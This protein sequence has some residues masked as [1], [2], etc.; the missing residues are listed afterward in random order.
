MSIIIKSVSY[1]HSDREILFQNISFAINKGEKAALVGN[2]GTGKSTL[3]QIIAGQLQASAGEVIFTEKPYYVPQ[4]LG[5]YDN[6]T[7]AQALGIEQ[8]LNAYKA[9]LNGDASFENFALLNDDWMIEERVQSAFDY[10]HL[11]HLPLHQSMHLLSGGEKTKVFLAG[12]LIHGPGIVL[13]DEP[14]NHL[15]L[16]S[17]ELLY[18]FNRKSKE[19][20]LLVSHDRTLLNQLDL[21]FELSKTAVETFGGNYDF[22]K[23]QKEIKSEALEAQL[24]EKE[25]TLKQTQQK[26]RELIEQR[27]KQEIRGKAHGQKHSA[28]KNE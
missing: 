27:Q 2:N 14:S 1:I 20:I 22:Y 18:E 26:A 16:E 25:K 17:R 15:D 6:F 19:T 12:I 8:K 23:A 13:L 7:I 10:W 9:I 21:T 11:Q 28:G 3:L 24:G 4:H 5:Q